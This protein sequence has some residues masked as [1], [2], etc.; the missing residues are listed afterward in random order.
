MREPEQ[1]GRAPQLGAK[2][3]GVKQQGE[4]WLEYKLEVMKGH[5]CH[6]KE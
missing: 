6:A 1:L 3:G 4:C 2:H 5:E